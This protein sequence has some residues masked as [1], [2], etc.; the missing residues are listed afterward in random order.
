MT[1]RTDSPGCA[2]QD[3]IKGGKLTRGLCATH[4]YRLRV[5][6]D[7]QA[8]IPI[9]T[10]GQ[11]VE[12]QV[13]GCDRRKP[14][15]RGYCSMHYQ[16]WQHHG[17]PMW[18]PPKQPSTCIVDDCGASPTVGKGLCRK[19]FKRLHRTGSTAD[20]VREARTLGPCS[21]DTCSNVEDRRGLCSM[22]YTRW[23]KHGDATILLRSWNSQA[24]LT[25]SENGC[26]I[27]A[28]TQGL[29]RR[30]WVAAYHAKNRSA[31]NARMRE[32]YLANREEYYAKANRR[33]QRIEA[34]M[35]AL[36]RALSADYRRAIAADACAYCGGPSSQVD[37]YFPIA[38]GGTDHWW[39]LLRA[40]EPCNKSKAAHC[41]T[42]FFLLRGG[43]REPV[44]LADVA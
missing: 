39:N 30:H 16:R 13:E 42:W 21:I 36:D 3:C 26:E 12:C 23:R 41:G 15:R 31:R 20:P 11:Q 27:A 6:G 8:H 14:L 33:R 24:G 2:V 25:C 18:E 28:S 7:V 17:D 40:C 32:H 38:K 43:G 9:K 4:Y 1:Q 29:C 22:H 37:H 44:D 10:L 5:H 19:H 34:N 35:D